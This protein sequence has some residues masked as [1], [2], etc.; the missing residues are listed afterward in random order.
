MTHRE[1]L[2]RLYAEW[3]RGDMSR[4]DI[5]DP[6]IQSANYGVVAETQVAEFSGLQALRRGMADWLGAFRMP[7]ALDAEE[8]RESGDRFLVLVRWRGEG[9]ESGVPI[10]AEGAHLWEFRGGSAVRFDVYR[11]REEALAAFRQ[12]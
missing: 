11:D 2:E 10:D 3:G 4:A 1:Q 9:K 5:F 6:E 7:L 12:G 8:I